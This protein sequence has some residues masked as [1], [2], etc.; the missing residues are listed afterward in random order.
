ME[1]GNTFI[2]RDRNITQAHEWYAL[3]AS[4]ATTAAQTVDTCPV[5]SG[6]ECVTT[7]DVYLDA[8]V[9]GSYTL[10]RTRY[11]YPEEEEI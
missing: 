9:V 5:L 7:F 2:V 4:C 11:Y 1:G 6:Y 10:R 8:R 3:T